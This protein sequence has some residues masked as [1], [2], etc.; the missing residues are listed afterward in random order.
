VPLAALLVIGGLKLIQGSDSG[1]A[2]SAAPSELGAGGADHAQ[3]VKRSHFTLALP[4]G[5]RQTHGSGGAAFAAKA[6]GADA[7]LWVERDPKLTLDDFVTR[8]LEQ[9]RALAGSAQVISRSG[10]PAPESTI[11]MLAA[12]SPANQPTY[13]VELRASGPYRYYLAT[14][15]DPN[16]ASREAADGVALIQNSFVPVLVG[17]GPVNGEGKR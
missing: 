9:L 10:G 11:V 17:Q 7:T 3:L 1:Q 2:P 4:P 14:T 8:S 13:Q 6:P 5:G 15:L 16:A 12:T